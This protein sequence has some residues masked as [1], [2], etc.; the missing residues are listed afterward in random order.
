MIPFL[1]ERPD[2]TMIVPI[3]FIP[4]YRKTLLWS[5]ELQGYFKDLERILL[6]W[7]AMFLFEIPNAKIQAYFAIP[8][9]P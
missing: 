5:H 8:Y 2:L 4:S 7:F 6:E 9:N 3:L 1:C